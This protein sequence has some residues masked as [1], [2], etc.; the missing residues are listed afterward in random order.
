MG[1]EIST[2]EESA[3]VGELSGLT[4]SLE[5]VIIEAPFLVITLTTFS[6]VGALT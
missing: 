3:L 4:E 5:G 6:V 1:I 2:S